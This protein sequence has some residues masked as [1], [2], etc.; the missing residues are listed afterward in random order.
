MNIDEVF[1]LRNWWLVQHLGDG[2]EARI[3]F[4]RPSA[5]IFDDVDV[6]SK[7]Y[8]ADV[9]SKRFKEVVGDIDV[10]LFGVIDNLK[11]FRIY[12]AQIGDVFLNIRQ[13]EELA[14]KMGFV[15]V[16]FTAQLWYYHCARELEDS[17]ER[18][19]LRPQEEFVRNDGERL[20]LRFG[21]WD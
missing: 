7:Q 5:V 11:R 1:Q 20:M 2:K 18:C 9:L 10:S 13:M 8:N 16:K 3:Y 12:D 21:R 4:R 19:I 17:G 14:M 15:P 6:L